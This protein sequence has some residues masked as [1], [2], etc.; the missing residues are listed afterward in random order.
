MASTTS[1][2]PVMVAGSLN[3][4]LAGCCDTLPHAGAD[5]TPWQAGDLWTPGV[6]IPGRGFRQRNWAGADHEPGVGCL[7]N[8][9]SFHDPRGPCMKRAESEES[10]RLSFESCK[11]GSSDESRAI[12]LPQYAP[13]TCGVGSICRPYLHLESRLRIR[14]PAA[15]AWRRWSGDIFCSFR[16]CCRIYGRHE[17]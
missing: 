17:R 4:D 13:C 7:A 8:D 3:M 15:L 10:L 1:A 2:R 11:Q 5:S 9:L 16:L 12:D 14:R 6:V